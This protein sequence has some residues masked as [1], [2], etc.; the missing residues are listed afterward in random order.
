MVIMPA[1]RTCLIVGA[2]TGIGKETAECLAKKDWT[3]IITGRN[4]DKGNKV[5]LDLI[6]ICEPPNSERCRL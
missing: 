3:V 5:G 2:T 1:K 6:Q 4:Q